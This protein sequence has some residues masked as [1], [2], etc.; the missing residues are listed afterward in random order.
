MAVDQMTADL[1][2]E[3]EALR[4]EVERLREREAGLLEQHSRDSAELRRVCAE[5]DEAR[6]AYRRAAAVAHPDKGGSD[7]QMAELNRAWAR[8]Q[9]ALS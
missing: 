6:S 9:E 7:A 5:R 4:A 1:L 2:R 8:A 3:N